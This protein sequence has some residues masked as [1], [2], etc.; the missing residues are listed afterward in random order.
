MVHS[1]CGGQGASYSAVRQGRQLHL[2][3]WVKTVD[4]LVDF[5]LGNDLVDVEICKLHS[6]QREYM[7]CPIDTVS[8]NELS[9]KLRS[10]E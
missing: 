5:D 7:S 8:L 2:E 6:S 4:L 1:D 9:S 10:I 3:P